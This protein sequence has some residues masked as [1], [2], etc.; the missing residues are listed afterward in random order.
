ML[1]ERGCEVMKA[2]QEDEMRASSKSPQ[3]KGAFGFSIARSPINQSVMSNNTT[4]L[5][6][7]LKGRQ[8]L[9]PATLLRIAS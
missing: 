4:E 1:A 5:Y 3:H 6:D 7:N 8:S 2:I 9:T